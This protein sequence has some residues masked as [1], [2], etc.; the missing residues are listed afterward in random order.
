MSVRTNGLGAPKRG[1]TSM[2]LIRQI[3]DALI[4][5]ACP[6]SPDGSHVMV[7]L[8]DGVTS[9]SFCGARS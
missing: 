9:C 8:A 7:T 6:K 1:D 2:R 3:R 5:W 4:V